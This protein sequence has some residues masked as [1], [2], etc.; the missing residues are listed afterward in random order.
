MFQFRA[1]PKGERP[2]DL[3]ALTI[4]GLASY[5]KKGK[6]I[7]FL[8]GAGVSVAAGIPDFR[9]PDGLYATL[10]AERLTCT[11]EE[12][13]ILK[14][15]PSMVVSWAIFQRNQFPYHEVRKPFILGLYEKKW[16]ATL[17]HFFMRVCQDKG[18]CEMIYSQNIDGL[19]IQA[20]ITPDH[21]VSVHGTILRA[22]C[23]FCGAEYPYDQ[24]AAKVRSNIRNIY[25]PEDPDSPAVSSHILCLQC[26]KP[27]VKPATVLFGRSLPASFYDA[28]QKHAPQLDVL[29]VAGTS[30]NVSPANLLPV[31]VRK[32][33][34]RVVVN[35]DMVGED[36]G[37]DCKS[38]TRDMF[39]GGDCDK[40]FLDLAKE[41]GWLEDLKA[42]KNEMCEKSR[43]L[44]K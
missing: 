29:F 5:I 6:R 19:D 12:L 18:L 7:G 16:K 1:V 17:S 35:R 8:I 21:M 15:D 42:Y 2:G 25:T 20:G 10:K 31:A 13:A 26:Q 9:S 4:E 11:A 34:V 43:E 24:Y 37:I 27:G 38:D 22:E 3:K 30:L 41:L 14:R 33:C 23:E 39:L 28:Q 32:D 40:A 36:L 44:L